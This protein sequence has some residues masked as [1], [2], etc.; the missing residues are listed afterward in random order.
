MFVN[1]P[2][3]FKFIFIVQISAL[4]KKLFYE[5]SRTGHHLSV[6]AFDNINF[7]SIIIASYLTE[8]IDHWMKATKISETMIHYWEVS[9]KYLDQ[10]AI[11]TLLGKIL[12]FVANLQ[13]YLKVRRSRLL[14]VHDISWKFRFRKYFL[15]DSDRCSKKR[16]SCLVWKPLWWSFLVNQRDY[17]RLKLYENFYTCTSQWK[18]KCW[19]SKAWNSNKKQLL[20]SFMMEAVII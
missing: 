9:V 5:R 2:P 4:Q 11:A 17:F 12:W 19:N 10:N 13:V 15:F 14:Q 18:L 7:Q 16:M 6:V 8:P 1:V 3:R 20:N